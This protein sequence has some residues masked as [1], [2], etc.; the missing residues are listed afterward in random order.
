MAENMNPFA[1]MA[2]RD[3]VFKDYY[4]NTVPTR[5]P[6]MAAVVPLLLAGVAGQD[7]LLWQ[8]DG[9]CLLGPMEEWADK[10]YSD[11]NPFSPPVMMMRPAYPYQ[12]L[13][14]QSFVL[15]PN[16][17]VQ[18][19]EVSGMP[20]EDYDELIER[21]FDYLVE[22]VVPRQYHN[23]D[24]SDP[25]KMTWAAMLEN[26]MTNNANSAF[27]PPYMEFSFKKGYH[28]GGSLG[29]GG[30]AE[31]PLDFL[32]DQLRGF[33]HLSVDI[34]RRRQQVIDACEV[35]TPLMQK[36]G[37]PPVIDYQANIFY[38]LHM[39]TFMRPKDVEEIY[40][41][42]YRKLLRD[43]VARGIRPYIFVEDD[44][45]GILDMLHDEFP[46]GCML[47]IDEGDP[48][49]FKEKLGKKFLLS[50]M[51]PLETMR[52]NTTENIL[53]RAKEFLD[54]ML[55]GGEYIFGFGKNPLQASDLNMDQY[56]ALTH[57][58]HENSYYPNAGEKFG[59]PLNAEGFQPVAE[60]DAPIKS[61]YILSWED[62]KKANPYTPDYA[63]PKFAAAD[64]QVFLWYMNLLF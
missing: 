52:N 44:W 26:T 45:T 9:N 49:L 25:V 24:L 2:E 5:M 50:G 30:S 37:M 58:V 43:N 47:Q 32:A 7:P 28:Q 54:I 38:P 61:R 15:G 4:S 21:G 14:S 11:T 3:Q 29:S 63:L 57:F 16:G 46:A 60:W 17:Q 39:P 62:F 13:G 23:L 53:A 64:H 51:F 41:P 48:K 56:A 19:P 12:V 1:L 20:A 8:Y 55:P 22:K 10:I 59:T 27:F 31:A 40:M 34:R 35:L 6:V 33:S 42:S 18:H 36:M